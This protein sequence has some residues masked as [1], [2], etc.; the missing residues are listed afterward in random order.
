MT[1]E[2]DLKRLI[3]ENWKDW[4]AD[5]P[6]WLTDNVIASVPDEYLPKKEVKRLKE[7]W[8]GERRKSS[9]LGIEMANGGGRKT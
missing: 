4:M 1:F 9:V 5:R 7:G 6:E 2:E 8:G 3:S